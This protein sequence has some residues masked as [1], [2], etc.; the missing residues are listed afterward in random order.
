M[1]EINGKKMKVEENASTATVTLP[2]ERLLRTID[3]WQTFEV[4]A[5]VVDFLAEDSNLYPIFYESNIRCFILEARLRHSANGSTN[6]SVTVEKLSNGVAQGSGK[7]MLAA[8][9]DVTSNPN[10]IQKQGATSV[11]A[12]A[13]I[14]PGDSLSLRP[15]GT[16][17]GLRDVSVTVIFGTHLR[18]MPISESTTAVLVGLG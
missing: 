5:K 1:V 3:D 13:Q 8:V 4:S 14:G 9:F 2:E 18:D 16:L 7:S 15:S 11:L 12:A 6:A 10:S 17:S